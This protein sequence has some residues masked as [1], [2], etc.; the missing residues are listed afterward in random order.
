MCS[1]ASQ[2]T[3]FSIKFDFTTIIPQV[4]LFSFVFWEKLKTPKQHF[5]ICSKKSLI[6]ALK[7]IIDSACNSANENRVN[8][9]KQKLT[10]FSVVIVI[11]YRSEPLPATI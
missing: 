5:E 3:K 4:D 8:I 6:F 7:L 2:A 11:A 9:Q 1:K 10:Y